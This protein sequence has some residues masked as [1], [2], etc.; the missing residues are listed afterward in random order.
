MAKNCKKI[1]T[2]KS[3]YFFDKKLQFTYPQAFLKDAEA[4]LEV[5][6]PQKGTYAL[7]NMEFLFFLLPYLCPPLPSILTTGDTQEDWER[8]PTCWREWG[9]RSKSAWSSINHSILR[10]ILYKLQNLRIIKISM[11]M[12]VCMCIIHAYIMVINVIVLCVYAYMAQ[13]HVLSIFL[14]GCWLFCLEGGAI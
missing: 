6:S 2:W 13:S 5:F 8:E 9:R 14:S 12:Y 3:F 4:T 10:D 1:Y 11:D 7:Q